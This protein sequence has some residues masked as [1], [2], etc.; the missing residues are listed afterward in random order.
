M[1]LGYLSNDE[2]VIDLKQQIGEAYDALEENL[3]KPVQ[4]A[5][6]K[7]SKIKEAVNS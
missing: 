2:Q 5:G 1:K 7:S 6:V 4:S 3:T